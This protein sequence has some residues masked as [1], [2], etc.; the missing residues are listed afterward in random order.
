MADPKAAHPGLYRIDR[1]P[2]PL[3]G[4][5]CAGCGRLAFPPNPYGCEGCGA[6]ADELVTEEIPGHG[7]L[8]AFATVHLHPGKD[9]EAPFTVGTIVLDAG[10]TL[11]ATLTRATDDGLAIGQ[12]VRSQLVPRHS[13]DGGELLELRFAVEET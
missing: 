7:E 13:E 5:R 12:R 3:L 4:Q 2:P 9:I 10:P 6:E 8:A 1:E 11:R